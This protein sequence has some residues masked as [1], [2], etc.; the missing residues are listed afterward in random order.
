MFRDNGRSIKIEK[1]LFFFENDLKQTKRNVF[2]RTKF[3]VNEL[4]ICELEDLL[5]GILQE[6]I[7]QD[8]ARS[9][10]LIV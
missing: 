7:D 10:R 8:F 4:L 9:L 2:V 5:D 1:F 6:L 3:N